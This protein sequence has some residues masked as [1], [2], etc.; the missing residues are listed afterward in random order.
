MAVGGAVGCR[1]GGGAGG[2]KEEI[3]EEVV[4]PKKEVRRAG[5]L[6]VVKPLPNSHA[7][8]VVM[9]KSIGKMTL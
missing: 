1:G 3:K 6:S 2:S 5:F 4:S 7:E 8:W 9:K